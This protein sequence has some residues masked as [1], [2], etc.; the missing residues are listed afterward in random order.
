[1]EKGEFNTATE[2]MDLYFGMNDKDRHQLISAYDRNLTNAWNASKI[3]KDTLFEC[4]I[5]GEQYNLDNLLLEAIKHASKCASYR[6][7]EEPQFNKISF[8][9]RV[10]IL[11]ER[12]KLLEKCGG[13]ADVYI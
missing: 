12:V 9:T 7:Y 10:K 5:A 4:I 8:E 3:T 6:L 11:K 13:I 2:T 1:M